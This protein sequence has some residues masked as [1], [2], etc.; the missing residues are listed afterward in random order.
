[1]AEQFA[2]TLQ[3]RKSGSSRLEFQQLPFGGFLPANSF[4]VLHLRSPPP[5]ILQHKSISVYIACASFFLPPSLSPA[6]LPAC[7]SLSLYLSLVALD[8]FPLQS[9]GLMAKFTDN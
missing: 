3:P 8:I 2:I 6:H 7:F 1:M 5:V 9:K 4:I